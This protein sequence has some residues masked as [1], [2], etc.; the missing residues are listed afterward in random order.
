MSFHKGRVW[1]PLLMLMGPAYSGCT[2]GTGGVEIGSID[3][4][5]IYENGLDNADVLD[6]TEGGVFETVSEITNDSRDRGEDRLPI[7]D[8][9]FFLPWFGERLCTMDTGEME[10]WFG[11]PFLGTSSVPPDERLFLGGDP[12]RRWG[13]PKGA[14]CPSGFECLPPVSPEFAEVC[15]F[16]P[17]AFGAIPILVYEPIAFNGR[18]LMAGA[19]QGK[20]AD[21]SAIISL[22]LH[23]FFEP[24][25]FAIE[26][27]PTLRGLRFYPPCPAE[28]LTIPLEEARA[29][30]RGIIDPTGSNGLLLDTDPR[31]PPCSSMQP[32]VNPPQREMLAQWG[33]FV[34]YVVFQD[35]KEKKCNIAVK[36]YACGPVLMFTD[37]DFEFIMNMDAE[38]VCVGSEFDYYTGKIHRTIVS[39]SMKDAG[40]DDLPPIYDWC[41]V[42]GDSCRDAAVCEYCYGT[43]CDNQRWYHRCYP[44]YYP[45]AE[46]FCNTDAE[47]GEHVPRPGSFN[48]FPVPGYWMVWNQEDQ[49][50]DFDLLMCECNPSGDGSVSRCRRESHYD[51]PPRFRY[52]PPSKQFERIPEFLEGCSERLLSPL[53]SL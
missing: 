10:K 51:S 50:Y 4:K 22:N 23:R 40:L 45:P 52:I 19:D 38:E 21:P 47:T 5:G 31:F 2:K 48:L 49:A 17:T 1:I 41:K 42:A 3:P 26:W 44:D 27:E 35:F 43:A 15:D 14:Q 16:Q 39:K 24:L 32:W 53:K 7:C 20:N 33:P 30:L 29:I 36:T 46:P 12:A 11:C 34:Q 9:P 37:E 6:P 25:G 28:H 8:H 13:L 18:Y